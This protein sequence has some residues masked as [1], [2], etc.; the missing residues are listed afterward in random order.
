MVDQKVIGGAMRGERGKVARWRG[1]RKEMS[2]LEPS[3][4]RLPQS[5]YGGGEEWGVSSDDE[6]S[7]ACVVA[8]ADEDM[9]GR[10]L[11]IFPM[12]RLEVDIKRIVALEG[13][14]V[15]ELPGSGEGS[16]IAFINL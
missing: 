7:H 13:V 10:E 16:F 8:S 12:G 9:Q 15:N 14:E 11:F 1:E 4:R 6:L 3:S 2:G 5:S